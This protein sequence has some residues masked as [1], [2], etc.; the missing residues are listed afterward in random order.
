MTVFTM[1]CLP[2]KKVLLRECKRHTDR[3]IS[4][5][6]YAVGVCILGYPPVLPGWGV[7]TLGARYLGVSP[8]RPDQ[9]GRYLEVPP[10]G[11][12]GDRYLGVPPPP[13][14]PGGGDRYLRVQLPAVWTW[15]GG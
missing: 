14:G 1:R 13:L 9:G 7:G 12:G 8:S 5:T 4:S 6:P 10:S 11:P 2:S 15:Q 3:S